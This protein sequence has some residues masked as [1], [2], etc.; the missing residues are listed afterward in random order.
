MQE[1]VIPDETTTQTQA[2]PEPVEAPDQPATKTPPQ[3][4]QPAAEAE[5]TAA[6]APVKEEADHL[7]V[8]QWEVQ[9]LKQALEERPTADDLRGL[10]STIE[11]LRQRLAESDTAAEPAATAD[12]AAEL[13]QRL[14]SLESDLG[15]LRTGL[16][17]AMAPAVVNASDV[18]P[19]VLQSAFEISLT[20]LYKEIEKTMGPGA[21]RSAQI[22]MEGVRRSSS[23]TGFFSLEDNRFVAKGLADAI[24]RGQLSPYQMQETFDELS[25]RLAALIPHYRPQPLSELII[26]GSSAFVVSTVTH[27][28]GQVETH[29]AGVDSVAGAHSS[30]AE[31]LA[32]L[33]SRIAELAGGAEAWQETAEKRLAALESRGSVGQTQERSQRK[34]AA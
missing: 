30:I 31:E 33:E 16:R 13:R 9:G 20:T 23:G 3:E 17:Q 21:L 32:K 29:L 14:S 6:E 5:M 15:E 28:A 8:M 25:R 1:A 19:E 2:A 24:K 12:E 26:G 4:F 11:E 10:Q 18:P 27:V 34:Q 22:V 7:A